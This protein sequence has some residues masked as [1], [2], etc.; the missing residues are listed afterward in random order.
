MTK[1]SKPRIMNNYDVRKILQI[2]SSSTMISRQIVEEVRISTNV[3]E[4]YIVKQQSDYT[5]RKKLKITLTK[6]NIKDQ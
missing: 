4:K 3:Y 5:K 2:V 1:K 6:N